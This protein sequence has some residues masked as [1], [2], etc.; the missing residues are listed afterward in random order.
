MTSI[1]PAA[2][3][4]PAATPAP[5][6]NS[7][8]SGNQ[9]ITLLTAELKD[10]DPSNPMDPTQFT[11]QLVQFNSLEQLISINQELTPPSSSTSNAGAPAQS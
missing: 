10:Q 8:I 3:A 4:S 2:A 6:S 5:G 7:Q 1:P 9:F 11:S